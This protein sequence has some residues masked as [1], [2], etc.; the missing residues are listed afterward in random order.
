M[1]SLILYY[2][3]WG[4]IILGVCFL[5]LSLVWVG[6]H[7]CDLDNKDRVVLLYI[8]SLMLLTPAYFGLDFLLRAAL[9]PQFLPGATQ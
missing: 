6:T 9:C 2:Q 3:I 8:I 5:I 1:E 4:C 7:Y